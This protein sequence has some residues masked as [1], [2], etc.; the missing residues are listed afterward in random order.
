MK[1]R[2]G[3]DLQEKEVGIIEG[4]FINISQSS[5]RNVEGGH[6]ELQQ[7]GALSIDGERME[8]TQSAAVVVRGSEI[9]LN[10]SISGVT[11]SN[12]TSINFSLSPLSLSRN[13]TTLHRSAA[14]I[15]AAGRV[16]SEKSAVLLV[17]TKKVEGNLTALLDWKSACALSAVAGGLWGFLS[18]FRKR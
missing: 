2:E 17:V 16:N 3:Q 12:S 5:V 15:V 8:A 6:V 4:E 18:L 7:V 11:V 1:A 9:N 14:G 13:D 10:Q